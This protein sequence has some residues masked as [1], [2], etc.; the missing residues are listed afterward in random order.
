MTMKNISILLIAGMLTVVACN[1]QQEQNSETDLSST[2]A[3][4]NELP[5]MHIT[6]LDSTRLSARDFS[7]KIVIVMFQP[8]CDH[9]QREAKQI[10]ENIDAFKAYQVYFVSSAG[11]EELKKFAGEYKL[12]NYS[13]VHFGSTTVEEIIS[14][15]GQ[16][17]APSVYIYDNGKLRQKFNGETDIAEIMKHL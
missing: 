9:C 15:L 12:D 6:L 11:G 5:T 2:P 16:I 3:L 1:K 10:R 8:D 17:D 13:H 7:G 14:S 4:V